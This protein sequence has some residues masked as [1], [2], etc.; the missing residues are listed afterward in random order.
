MC[1]HLDLIE[2]KLKL[3]LA[4]NDTKVIHLLTQ[5]KIVIVGAEAEAGVKMIVSERKGIRKDRWKS[6]SH[7]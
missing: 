4:T 7:L 2:F 5:E 1:G 6:K 3:A